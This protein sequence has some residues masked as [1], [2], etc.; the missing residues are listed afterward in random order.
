MPECAAEGHCTACF[1]E[2]H[3][4]ICGEALSE[5]PTADLPPFP[6]VYHDA[7]IVSEPKL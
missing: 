4:C 2:S 1:G 3:C 5:A 6:A 7:Y